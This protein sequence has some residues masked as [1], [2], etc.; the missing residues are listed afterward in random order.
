MREN[1]RTKIGG[2]TIIV[3]T[4][5]NPKQQLGPRVELETLDGGFALKFQETHSLLKSDV[6]EVVFDPGTIQLAD[7][8][9]PLLMK[10]VNDFQAV[11]AARSLIMKVS[12]V[13]FVKIT[14]KSIV[15]ATEATDCELVSQIISEHFY[16]PVMLSNAE[17]GR[18]LTTTVQCG[19][20]TRIRPKPK[21]R[22]KSKQITLFPTV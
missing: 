22:M 17:A 13:L 16:Y 21:S 4:L 5:G 1:Q 14:R 6:D 8:R 10:F 12:D 7:P 18:S 3:E 15:V 19:T 2:E 20:R 9:D 11:M